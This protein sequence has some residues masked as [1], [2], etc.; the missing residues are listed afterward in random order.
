MY[1]RKMYNYTPRRNYRSIECI[2]VW[3]LLEY[4]SNILGYKINTGNYTSQRKLERFPTSPR[5]PSGG[6]FF[7]IHLTKKYY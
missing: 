7:N 3:I 2:Q 4:P 5:P 1:Y 6:S